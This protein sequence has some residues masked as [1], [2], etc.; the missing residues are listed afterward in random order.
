MKLV[1]GLACLSDESLSMEVQ[2]KARCRLR[3][4]QPQCQWETLLR[5]Q[6][7]PDNVCKSQPGRG[8]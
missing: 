3:P 2:R 7:C 6:Q 8:C 4:E 1:A 5:C